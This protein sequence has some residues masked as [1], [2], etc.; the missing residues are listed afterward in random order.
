MR[1]ILIGLVLL[2][3]GAHAEAQVTTPLPKELEGVDITEHPGGRI[4]LDTTFF[5]EDSQ[6]VKIG[7]YF[8]AGRPV[9]LTLNYFECPMLCTLILNG[10]VTAMQ[11]MDWTPGKEFEVVTVSFNPAEGPTLASRK[12]A[13]YMESY[14]HPGTE[15]GWRFLTGSQESIH[16][17]TGAVGFHYRWNAETRQFMHQAAIFVLTP[18]GRLSRYLY[19][20]AF[21]PGTVRMSLLEAAG[22]KIG[23][24]LNQV[25]MYCYEYDPKTGSY[26]LA[27][28]RVMQIGVGLSALALAGVLS[29]LWIRGRRGR[30]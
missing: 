30:V 10:L 19:G 18:D 7:D 6:M 20:V 16:A 29:A 13:T 5:D 27:A 11:G 28:L 9:V 17:I 22:G 15:Q 24:P 21:D 4:A 3:I 14:G 8:K 25:V 12:K 23:S 1:A 26:S 2:L